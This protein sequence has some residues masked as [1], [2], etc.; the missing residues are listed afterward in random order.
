LTSAHA[1]TVGWI[2]V[3]DTTMTL[4]DGRSLAYTDCGAPD[5]PLV[6]YF[7]GAPTS[8][9]DLIGFEESF[10][11]F[12]VRVI[13]PDRPGYGRSSPRPGRGFNDWPHDVAAL[14]DHLG[15]ERFAV[16]GASSGGPY[17][18]ACAALLPERIVGAG[19]IAGVTDMGWPGAWEGYE[20]REATLMRIGDEA[21]AV[22]WCE[23]HYGP[24]G[25]KFLETGSEMAPA[26][27][28]FLEDEAR[29]TGFITTIRE[30]F[31]QG[32]GGFAQDITVQGR[33]WPFD[34]SVITAPTQVLHGQADTFVPIAHGRHTA[35]VIPSASLVAFPDHGHL[36]IFTEI[37]Q[38][39]ADLTHSP[40]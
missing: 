25:S 37:P 38:L 32:I 16:M 17:V 5:G 36:S 23:E 1:G 9:L 3:I 30:A 14:A 27:M 6:V 31:H 24:D 10:S 8:R 28:A 34:P 4:P 18:V 19:V 29:A 12:G 40:R 15:V 21:A 26:D 7:H 13:S 20:V 2:G 39:S 11:A 35:D 33:P 22:R